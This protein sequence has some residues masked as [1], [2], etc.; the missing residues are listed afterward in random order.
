MHQQLFEQFQAV[1]DKLQLF[2][3]VTRVNEE[4]H[5]KFS[6]NSLRH[7]E[8]ALHHERLK[9]EFQTAR[10]RLEAL[11]T[12]LKVHEKAINEVD[13]ARLYHSYAEHQ[14]RLIQLLSARKVWQDIMTGYNAIEVQR[15]TIDRLTR[16][17]EQRCTAYELAQRDTKR[18]H[19][20]ATPA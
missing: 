12:D 19:E 14:S 7:S 8:V 6:S 20:R 9:K 2:N 16:Q 3:T 15:A 17:Y 11:R 1:N 13:S 18:L 4:V 10:E 5:Q